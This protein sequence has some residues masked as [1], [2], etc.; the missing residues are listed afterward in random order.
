MR[1]GVRSLGLLFL[2]GSLLAAAC[3]LLASWPPTTAPAPP[4]APAPP[5]RELTLCERPARPAAAAQ[6]PEV[7]ASFRA[8]A[9]IWLEKRR[10]AGAANNAPGGPTQI[11]DAFEIELRPTGSEQAPWVGVLRYCEQ[12]LQCSD[13]NAASCQP[14][15]RTAV[16]ELFRFQG[17][18]WMY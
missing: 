15:K 4:V 17:E 3:Q 7:E 13:A 8:F 12:V 10:Q 16:T 18:E 1:A 14:S 2:G 11:L 5:E 6:D 9:V